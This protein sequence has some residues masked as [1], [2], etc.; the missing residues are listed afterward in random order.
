MTC[1]R[2]AVNA[3]PRREDQA[4]NLAAIRTQRVR[5]HAGNLP[6]SIIGAL[7]AA[8]ILVG[9]LWHKLPAGTL[10]AWLAVVVAPQLLRLA[11]G[12]WHRRSP[13]G[14]R[15]DAFW[16]GCY[17][18]GVLAHGLAWVLA[19]QLPLPAGDALAE[20]LRSTVLVAL[21]GG[22]FALLAFDLP[23]ALCFG[24]PAQGAMCLHLWLLGL[25]AYQTLAVGAAATLVFLCLAA[26]RTSQVL[27]RYV[28]LQAA[29]ARQGD[30]LRCSQASLAQQSAALRL[31]LD[32]TSQGIA[33]AGADGRLVVFNR[34]A[35]ELLDLP[36]TL[37]L[38]SIGLSGLL[39]FQ[40][41]R[42]DFPPGGYI[43]VHGLAQPLPDSP[44][45][46]PAV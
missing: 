40:A 46:A 10:L 37:D 2:I 43:D 13:A 28:T 39:A 32:S 7:L 30:V 22:S 15:T 35:R 34:R 11:I 45:D 26:H 18:A 14:Q 33:M 8:L 4:A 3:R 17:R 31:T 9:L 36:P 24:L 25:P 20:A 41:G 21:L 23:A 29:E 1:M 19:C 42:G 6:F 5:S 16:L 27:R 12:L 38:D 44:A